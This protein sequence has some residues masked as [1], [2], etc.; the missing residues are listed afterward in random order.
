MPRGSMRSADRVPRSEGIDA[1]MTMNSRTFLSEQNVCNRFCSFRHL[2]G[3][4]WECLTHGGQVHVC[5]A[6]CK[7]RIAMDARGTS[8]C[9]LSKRVFS[10]GDPGQ[11]AKRKTTEEETRGASGDLAMKRVNSGGGERDGV[12]REALYINDF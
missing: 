9:R 7:Q 5:D 1:G 2:F 3:N 10:N 6:N 11:V 8:M 12:G 4:S